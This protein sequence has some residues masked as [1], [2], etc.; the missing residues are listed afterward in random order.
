MREADVI[1]QAVGRHDRVLGGA[2]GYRSAFIGYFKRKSS[3]SDCK[4]E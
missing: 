4:K 2:L 3:A 1:H